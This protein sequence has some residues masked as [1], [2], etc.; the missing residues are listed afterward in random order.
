MVYVGDKDEPVI[1]YSKEVRS[2][3]ALLLVPR[4]RKHWLSPAASLISGRYTSISFPFDMLLTPF[5][6]ALEALVCGHGYDLSS[7][8]VRDEPGWVD[9]GDD[10]PQG[11]VITGGPG[12]KNNDSIHAMPG[13]V[14]SCFLHA[15]RARLVSPR[16]G[17]IVDFSFQ[18]NEVACTPGINSVPHL[19]LPSHQ[20]RRA[21]A[22]FRISPWW[23]QAPC[24]FARRTRMSSWL[25]GVPSCQLPNHLSS[26]TVPSPP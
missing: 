18:V 10:V 15:C 4:P 22:G 12:R 16:A 21:F 17:P 26:G 7:L 11:P 9:L 6:E 23:D 14:G 5:N 25:S 1:V 20:C 24:T 19:R 13:G 2:L 8:A 3:I